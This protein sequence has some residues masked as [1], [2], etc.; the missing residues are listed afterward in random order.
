MPPLLPH[1]IAAKSATMMLLVQ[2]KLPKRAV[3]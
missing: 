3:A 1:A 2:I